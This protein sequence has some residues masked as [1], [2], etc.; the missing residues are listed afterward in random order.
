MGGRESGYLSHQL[1]G[2]RT[3]TEEADRI[4]MEKVWRLP[5]GSIAGRPGL[6]ATDM[7]EALADGS[8]KAIWIAATNPA[9]SMP[10]LNRVQAGLRRAELVIVQDIYHPTETTRYADL[11][12][13]AAQWAE[14]RGTS[15]NSE[16]L[17]TRS[18]QLVTP[19]GEAQ[20]DWWIFARVARELG[21]PNFSHECTEEVW[22]EM[23]LATR[24]TLCD[25]WGI[26]N[27]RLA[28]GPRQ[29]PCRGRFS[30]GDAR[31]YT[32]LRFPTPDGR[33]R[34]AVC[35]HRPPAEEPCADFPLRLTTGRIL[36]QWHTM[37]RTGKVPELLAKEPEPFLEIHPQDAAPLGVEAEAWVEIVSRRGTMRAKAR[38]TDGIPRGTVFSTFHWNDER[39][40]DLAVNDLLASDSDPISR[41]PELKHCAVRVRRPA[42]EA[43][44]QCTGHGTPCVT[45]LPLSQ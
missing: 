42:G 40:A 25:Q 37:T 7:F 43:R 13:P 28:R 39:G 11:L 38:L 10:D 23:R 15:T 18:E 45:E 16:R 35:A 14:K 8:V 19:P 12:L 1:P 20:P 17:V 9:A 41:Q 44:L 33:A 34:F 6:T 31:R 5:P 30:R 2:Y 32:D 36:N 21:F 29:W 26:T 27:R 22:D 24:G 3:V 4:A